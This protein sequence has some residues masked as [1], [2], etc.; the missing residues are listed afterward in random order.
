MRWCQRRCRGGRRA[1]A[2]ALARRARAGG[3]GIGG[4][5]GALAG[6]SASASAIRA[7]FA[8]LAQGVSLLLRVDRPSALYAL[9]FPECLL[10]RR[11]AAGLLQQRGVAGEVDWGR[12]ACVKDAVVG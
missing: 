1:A 9:R 7:R 6:G 5:D 3:G 2:G 4:G 11:E 8:K 10:T 12:V